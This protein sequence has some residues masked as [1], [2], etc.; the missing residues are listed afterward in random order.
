MPD[1][2]RFFEVC[3]AEHKYK[4]VFSSPFYPTV[5]KIHFIKIQIMILLCHKENRA[6]E[7]FFL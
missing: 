3:V 4:S 5:A 1:T 7:S 2:D 6:L